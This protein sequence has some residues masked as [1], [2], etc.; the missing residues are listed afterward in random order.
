MSLIIHKKAYQDFL[1][2][3]ISLESKCQN[4]DLKRDRTEV[5]EIWTNLKQIFQKRI[6][7]LTDE[8]LDR[9]VAS[10]WISLQ[11]EIQREFRLLNTDWLFWM[12]S[13]Q[14]DTKR[15]RKQAVQERLSKLIKYCQVILKEEMK[16]ED[17]ES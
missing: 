3:L 4:Y 13:R 8:N 2:L 7:S 15:I 6:V 9:K 16:A 17:S 10:R 11:T 1:I 14:Q 12:S 5:E